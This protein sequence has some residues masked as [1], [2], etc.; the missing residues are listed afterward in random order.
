MAVDS[1]A[2]SAAHPVLKHLRPY[3]NLPQTQ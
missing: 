2:Y 3:N 1:T